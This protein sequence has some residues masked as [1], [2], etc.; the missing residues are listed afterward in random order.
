MDGVS[1]PE[2][3]DTKISNFG[4]GVLILEH[5]ISDDVELK[6][7]NPYSAKSWL[8]INALRLAIN[9]LTSFVNGHS[10]HH[11]LFTIRGTVNSMCYLI[12]LIEIVKSLFTRVYYYFAARA[13]SVCLT[14][15]RVLSLVNIF[16]LFSCSGTLI[17]VYQGL[18]VRVD[19]GIGSEDSCTHVHKYCSLT[20][21]PCFP[22]PHNYYTASN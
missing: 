8:G 19:K 13:E 15:Q 16:S 12:L 21:T 1:S 2:K 9:Q 17:V 6:K 11:R 22:F 7:K 4:Q 20:I 3:N 14:K 10:L 18:H 5:I